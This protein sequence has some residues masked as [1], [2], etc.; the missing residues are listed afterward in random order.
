MRVTVQVSGLRDLDKALGQLPLAAAKTTLRN[1]LKKAA[2]PI[3]EKAK[4]NAPIGE[5]VTRTARRRDGTTKTFT[6]KAGTLR[7]SIVVTTKLKNPV[8]KS[9]YHAALRAGL[10]KSVAVGAMR[11]ARRAAAAAGDKYFMEM[12]VGP[13]TRAPYAHLVEFGT[14]HSAPV[15]F[16][17]P[18]FDAEKA[19]ALAIIRRELGK[20]IIAQAKR[21]A[22]SERYTADVKF[23]ASMA[24]LMAHEAGE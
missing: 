22:R 11:D 3:A 7:D 16:M 18:A 4:D 15:P 12:F 23:S 9:E 5:T 10:S 1:V 20:E 14:A 6:H 8:G 21:I 24:A 19:N 17:R 13:S 2:Q